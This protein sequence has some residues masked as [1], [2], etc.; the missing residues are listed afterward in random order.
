MEEKEKMRGKDRICNTKIKTERQRN[1]LGRE[2]A[3]GLYVLIIRMSLT[4]QWREIGLFAHSI[5][6][7]KMT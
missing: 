5:L 2:V 3:T 7:G 6:T 1:E 4:G